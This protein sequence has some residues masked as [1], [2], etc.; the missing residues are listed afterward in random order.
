VLTMDE[1][2]A[3]ATRLER[4]LEAFVHG[5]ST[6]RIGRWKTA[7]EQ[8]LGVKLSIAL[9]TSAASVRDQIVDAVRSLAS[10]LV[11][12]KQLDPP[13][14][15]QRLATSSVLQ[16]LPI[17]ERAGLVKELAAGASFFFEH[18]D[19]DP[20]GDLA[21]KYLEDLASLH[22]R[23]PPRAAGVEDALEDVAAYLRRPP[24]KMQSL[25]E[26]HYA[27]AL[28]ERLPADA[29]QRRVPAAAA[30]AALD[31]LVDSPARFLY[32]PVRLEWAEENRPDSITEQS[33]WLLGVDRRMLLFSAGDQP[34]VLWIGTSS[35]V[36][37][38]PVR[39]LLATACRLSGG[40]WQVP[41]ASRPLAIRLSAGLVAS[42]TSY[43]EPLLLTLGTATPQ[44]SARSLRA[45]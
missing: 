20:D 7:A 3:V 1:R 44:D 11:A 24:R 15:A 37:A 12:I 27:T 25:V 6:E 31:L 26:K 41:M 13:E 40:Q 8:R 5:K 4:F 32:G 14:A 38:Q 21:D 18:P 43:F 30:R 22:A 9:K 16:Q 42:Y 17:E 28:F 45:T 2:R 10:F 29:P 23:T 36:H 39:Q 34:R 35:D 19:L 33:L